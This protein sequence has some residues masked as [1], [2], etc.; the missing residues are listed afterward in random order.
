MSGWEIT[1]IVLGLIIL[2][3]LIMNAKDL[4]RYIKISNM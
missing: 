1:G 3:L 4:Y 2:G